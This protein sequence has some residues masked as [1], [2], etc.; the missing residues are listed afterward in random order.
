MAARTVQA[1]LSL[2]AM[3]PELPFLLETSHANGNQGRAG[4]I[5]VPD[6]DPRNATTRIWYSIFSCGFDVSGEIQLQNAKCTS[7]AG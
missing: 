3:N 5:D 4:P 6:A 7:K 1:R 2:T